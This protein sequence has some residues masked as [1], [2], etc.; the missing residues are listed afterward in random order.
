MAELKILNEEPS[1]IS[2]IL[3]SLRD[4]HKQ[5]DPLFFRENLKRIGRFI[6]LEISKSFNYTKKSVATPLGN[7]EEWCT[8]DDIVLISILRAAAP[9][10]EGFL[11]SYPKAEFG[12]I[13]AM[14]KEGESVEID[15]SY[16]AVPNIEDKRVIIIDPMLATGKSMVKT[17]NTLLAKGTPSNIDIACLVSAPEGVNYLEENISVP[18]TL[19]TCA[20]DSH[21]NDKFYIVPGLGDAGDL[22]FGRK[23]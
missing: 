5:R 2:E 8:N 14:R 15:L 23:I 19:W 18:Y 22:A 4:V 11:E 13:G 12:M 16:V 21:L 17:V 10:S 3:A 7:S 6:A 9:M 20:L 1:A